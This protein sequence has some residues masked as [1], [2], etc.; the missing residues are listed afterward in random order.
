MP[1]PICSGSCAKTAA[2]CFIAS[3]EGQ[4]NE[5]GVPVVARWVRNL[6]SYHEDAGLIP[7]PAQWVKDPPLL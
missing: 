4:Q 2:V 7:G 5:S 6:T 1:H 3:R